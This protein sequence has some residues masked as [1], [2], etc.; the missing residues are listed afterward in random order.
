VGEITNVLMPHRYQHFLNSL[1]TSSFGS[2][3]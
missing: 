2:R 3:P 1:L